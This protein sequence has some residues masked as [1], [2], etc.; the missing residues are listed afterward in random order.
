MKKSKN[1]IYYLIKK[2]NRLLFNINL[3][4]NNFNPKL[5]TT[6]KRLKKLTTKMLSKN[7]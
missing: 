1:R 4:L 7:C 2:Y 5:K 6:S 3:K